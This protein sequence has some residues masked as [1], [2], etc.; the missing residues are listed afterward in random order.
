V[1]S[2]H[3]FSPAVVPAWFT[4]ASD[5]LTGVSHLAT[6]R[7]MLWCFNH[8]AV[9]HLSPPVHRW[10]AC[11]GKRHQLLAPVHPFLSG[12]HRAIS[13][14]WT[15]AQGSY[16]LSVSSALLGS[17]APNPSTRASNH[18]GELAN[19]RFPPNRSRAPREVTSSWPVCYRSVHALALPFRYPYVL[20]MLLD[21]LN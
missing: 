20:W 12:R 15:T 4:A 6:L 7:H 2:G 5:K 19:S 18:P 11:H 3:C 13:N 9:S 14:S 16:E 17:Q 10:W 21:P 1:N 8:V